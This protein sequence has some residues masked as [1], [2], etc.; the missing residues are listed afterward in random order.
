MYSIW[1]VR[2][3]CGISTGSNNIP[4]QTTRQS[5]SQ[6][7]LNKNQLPPKSSPWTGNVSTDENLVI[8]FSDDDSGSDLETKGNAS[9]LGSNIKRP[10]SS[11]VKSNKFQ[12]STRSVPKAMPK[13]LSSNRTFI[14]SMTKVNGSNSK[15]AGSM[16]LGQVSRARN[17][18][19]T[20]KNFGSRERGRDQGV[21]SNDNKLQD[22]RHQ[23]ALRESELKLKAAQQI[24][25]S[26]SVMGK[27][28]NA[29]NLKNDAA[30]KYTPVSSEATQSEAKEPDKKRLK[31][32]TPYGIPQA[33]GSQQEIPAAKPIL[34]SKDSTWENCYPQERNKVDHSQKEIPLGRRESTIIRSQ[35]QPDKQIDNSLQNMP[36]RE[37]KYFAF[38][39][40][41]LKHLWSTS[42]LINFI[43]LFLVLEIKISFI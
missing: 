24:K 36:S 30:K 39:S 21:L 27:D 20:N 19:P 7:S 10:S 3:F 22:L 42:W 11:L 14:S 15:V 1:S 38:T 31:L 41:Y 28:H 34:L 2:A 12:Q 40:P 18:N 4:L 29:V 16:S 32:G 25:E 26:A 37:G 9:R 43:V 23:I 8:S 33:V 6:M 5:N 17:F 13:R 35:R